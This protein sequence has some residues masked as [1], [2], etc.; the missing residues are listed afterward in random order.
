MMGAAN[1]WAPNS[2]VECHLHTLLREE[3][4]PSFQVGNTA[5]PWSPQRS[6]WG[7]SE[8][9]SSSRAQRGNSHISRFTM[10]ATREAKRPHGTEERLVEVALK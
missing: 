5:R 6:R 9:F 7:K 8:N 10:G 3:N 4:Q 2:A 1:L